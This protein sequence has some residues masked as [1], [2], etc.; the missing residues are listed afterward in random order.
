[1]PTQI[2]RKAEKMSVKIKEITS[3]S[4]YCEVLSTSGNVYTVSIKKDGK[5][6]CDCKHFALYPGT[7]CSHVIAVIKHLSERNKKFKV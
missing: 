1:M 3:N 7:L 4:V 5:F 2:F 6:A